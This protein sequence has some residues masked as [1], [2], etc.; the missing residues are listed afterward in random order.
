MSNTELINA[1][2]DNDLSDSE[3]KMF[4]ER[5]TRDADLQQ[6]Y[7]FHEEIIE[8]IREVRKQSLKAR[9]DKVQVGGSAGSSWT[10]G[11]ITGLI[12]LVAVAGLAIYF[13]YPENSDVQPVQTEEVI[14]LDDSTDNVSDL[15]ADDQNN[16]PDEIITEISEEKPEE[17]ATETKEHSEPVDKTETVEP[18]V[19][20]S[21]ENKN[22]VVAPSFEDPKKTDSNVSL[23]EGE[24]TGKA[25]VAT[26]NLEV[27]VNNTNKRYEFHYA[28]ENKQLTLY[29]DF[30]NELYE[31]LEFNT[32]TMKSWFLSYGGSFYSLEQ[33]N[34]K[35]TSLEK[36]TDT[37]LLNT[38][39]EASKN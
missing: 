12:G 8:G 1:Y 27:A 7:K 31:I 39:K 6:E 14:V 29:G 10:A 11:K 22:P 4:E 30:Q 5:L 21:E 16:Q 35:I 23:P 32:A 17:N 33:T 36:V 28:L 3:K 34:G 18:E 38:L 13:F 15:P 9:L 19:K 26:E 37:A 25:M 2:F 20:V 24:V